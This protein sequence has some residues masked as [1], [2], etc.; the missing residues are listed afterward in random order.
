MMRALEDAEQE[1]DNSLQAIME[2]RQEKV[3][4]ESQKRF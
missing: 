3:A 1:Q 4:A 2:K